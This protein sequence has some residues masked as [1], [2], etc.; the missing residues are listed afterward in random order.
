MEQSTLSPQTIDKPPFSK[1][2]EDITQLLILFLAVRGHG[3]SSSLRTV[4]KHIRQER[5]DIVF[6]IFDVSQAWFHN[7]PVELRQMVTTSALRSKQIANLDNC[8]YEMGSLSEAQR[9]AFVASIVAQDYRER[10]EIKR[11]NHGKIEGLPWVVY[12][13]EEANVYFGSYSFRKNDA[14]SPVLQ[15][16][17]SV[18]RNYKLSAFLVATAEQGEISPSLRRRVSRLYGR[19]E[20]VSDLNALKRKDKGASKIVATMPKYNFLYHSG[21]SFGP[22]RIRDEVAQ[23]PRDHIVVE[24]PEESPYQRPLGLSWW[25][26]FF[27]GTA[28]ALVLLWL[29]LRN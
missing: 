9:R 10:Y 11:K 7:A 21:E 6:K 17:V 4:L 18:G 28:V 5:P 14:F 29:F 12:I 1:I 8:V 22:F 27:V 19:V 23:R 24:M 16:F 15:D 26:Q 20:S 2:A 13:F 25:Q 3:K